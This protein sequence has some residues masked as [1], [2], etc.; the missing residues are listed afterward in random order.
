MNY[1]WSEWLCQH[2]LDLCGTDCAGEFGTPLF[3][4]PNWDIYPSV[5][6]YVGC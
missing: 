4:F 5:A 6:E 3:S 2:H 1:I